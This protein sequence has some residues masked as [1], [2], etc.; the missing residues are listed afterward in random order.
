MVNK[1]D[2][3]YLAIGMGLGFSLTFLQRRRSRTAKA[4]TSQL[5]GR[6]PDLPSPDQAPTSPASAVE[7]SRLQRELDQAKLAYYQAVELGKFKAGFLARTSHELRSPLS[8]MIG[9]HQ[10]ILSDLCENPEEEREFIGQ[11][12]K[13][14]LDMMQLMD[15]LIEVSKIDQ[16]LIKLDIQ[17]VQLLEILQE[18]DLLTRLPA[19]NRNLKLEIARPDPGVYVLTDPNCLRQVLLSLIS[20]MIGQLHE[21]N[22]NIYTE[23]FYDRGYALICFED[24]QASLRWE[25]PIDL[26]NRMADH[27]PRS[28]LCGLQLT[29]NQMLLEAM[30]GQLRL[31]EPK[32]KSQ[33][34]SE[35]RQ[36]DSGGQAGACLQCWIPLIIPDQD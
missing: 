22:L 24:L 29:L 23:I 28:E 20:Q 10:I 1:A 13:L 4:R 35:Q 34:A 21:G 36:A 5:N 26:I 7:S 31:A 17:P 18:V 15:H 2:L 11:A 6:Y 14:A 33:P 16:G 32:A 30:D 3:A 25:E 19:K 8:S 27:Q 9:I 12:H